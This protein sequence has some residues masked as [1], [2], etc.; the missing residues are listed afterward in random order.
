MAVRKVIHEIKLKRTSKEEHVNKIYDKIFN[1]AKILKKTY[2]DLLE[3][4][5]KVKICTL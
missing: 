3:L 1:K 5:Q 2:F 4:T